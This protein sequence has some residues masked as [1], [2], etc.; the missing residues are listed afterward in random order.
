MFTASVLQNNLYKE[1]VIILWHGID[2]LWVEAPCTVLF[3]GECSI[4]LVERPS[5]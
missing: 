5:A 4:S 1:P 2:L 3:A